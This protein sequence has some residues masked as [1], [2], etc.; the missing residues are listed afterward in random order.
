[1]EPCLLGSRD[2][3][4]IK[5]DNVRGGV[6]EVTEGLWILARPLF[7]LLSK[8]GALE[9]SEVIGRIAGCCIVK[10]CGEARVEAATIGSYS[11]SALKPKLG[12]CCQ[13]NVLLLRPRP[14]LMHFALHQ[15][16]SG[17]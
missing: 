10:S 3:G 13:M 9:G 6:G 4:R 11:R 5:P 8:M 2:R 14:E 15:P 17:G 12:L 1:M 7:F 16:L